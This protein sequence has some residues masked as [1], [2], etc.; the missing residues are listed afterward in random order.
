MNKD[1]VFGKEARSKLLEDI[2]L[3]ANNIKVTLNPN[4][5]NVIIDN[6]DGIP[7]IT[8]DGVTVTR[9]INLNEKPEETGAKL[10]RDVAINTNNIIGDELQLLPSLH[11]KW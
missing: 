4:G 7:R 5:R 10:I 1:I 11:K 2:N 6:T 3:I 9:E 8:K